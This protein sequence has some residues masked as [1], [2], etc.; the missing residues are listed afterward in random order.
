M[1]EG[2]SL[3]HREADGNMAIGA[4]EENWLNIM[5]T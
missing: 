4:L 1:M 2:V 3:A 5:D